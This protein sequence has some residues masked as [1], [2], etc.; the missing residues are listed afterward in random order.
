M[1][2]VRIGIGNEAKPGKLQNP[3]FEMYLNNRC[4]RSL[5]CWRRSVVSPLKNRLNRRL[6]GRLVFIRAALLMLLIRPITTRV[7]GQ[8]AIRMSM[9]GAAAAQGRAAAAGTPGYYNLELGPTYWRFGSSL[10]LSYE[11]NVQLEQNRQEGDFVYTPSLNAQMRWPITQLQTLNLGIDAGY[12]GYVSHSSLNTFFLSPDSG[13]SFDVYVGDFV[14]NF[15]DRFSITHGSYQDP[16][17]TG[18]GAYSQFQNSAGVLATWDLN[19][20][21][22][23]LGYDHANNVELSGG[24]GQPGQSS[25]IFSSSVGY[26][27]KPAMVLGIEAGG[28]LL[29]YSSATTNYPYTAATQWNVGPYFRTPVT[30][31]ISISLDA[32]YVVN[33]PQSSG[34]LSSAQG[35]A[36]YY[37]T[38]AMTHRLNRF[39]QYSLNVGRNVSD[40]LFGGASDAYTANLSANWTVVE[41]LSLATTFLYQRGT[42]IGVVG[43][44]TYYQYGPTIS[45]GRALTKK[46]TSGLEYQYLDRGA[47]VPGQQYTLN[48]VTLSLS[49]QF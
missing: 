31:H 32:G 16:T 10:S 9:A 44:E 17:V 26:T 42:E 2:E 27:L 8:E 39:V 14:I 1:A 41:K 28:A 18:N 29:Q 34:S 48:V 7:A 19:K 13:L 3:W 12:S 40:N 21:V 30:E 23:N 43:G 49:Y 47:N 6:P 4:Q 46:L 36:S 24:L 20:L 25:E 15:H 22:V 11:D 45:L 33:T 35:Y 38:L 37:V 5:S